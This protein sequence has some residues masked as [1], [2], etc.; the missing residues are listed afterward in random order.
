MDLHKQPVFGL[1]VFVSGSQII[2]SGW[3]NNVV[4]WD[5]LQGTI[6][7]QFKDYPSDLLLSIGD[8]L[9]ISADQAGIIEKFSK[10]IQC[11]TDESELQLYDC[12]CSQITGEI[13]YLNDTDQT[14]LTCS[15]QTNITFEMKQESLPTIFLITYNKYWEKLITS[16]VNS[17]YEHSNLTISGLEFAKDFI[18]EFY[19]FNQNSIVL[20]L[21]FITEDLTLQNNAQLILKILSESLESTSQYFLLNKTLEFTFSETI[22]LCNPGFYEKDGEC[23]QSTVLYPSLAVTQSSNTL[24]LKFINNKTLSIFKQLSSYISVVEIVGYSAKKYNYHVVQ[25]S[26]TEFLIKFTFF[27]SILDGPKTTIKIDLP[28]SIVYSNEYTVNSKYLS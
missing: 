2:S 16:L 4:V 22:T 1:Q 23:I 15:A 6:I 28:Q 26:D 20:K 27:I 17:P 3:D 14:F 13:L 11:N 18:Y 5:F 21:S 9:I 10:N 19:T 8:D 7:K 25:E 24:K 12:G